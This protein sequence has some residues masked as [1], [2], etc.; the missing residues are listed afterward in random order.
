VYTPKTKHGVGVLYRYCS[1]KDLGILFISSLCSI[2]SGAAM[3][4]MTVLFGNLQGIFQ[5]YFNGDTTYDYF[6]ERLVSFVLYLVY[7][8]IGEFVVTYVATVGFI[9]TGERI[10]ARIRE[11]YLQCCMRQNIA[12]FDNVGAGEITTHITSNTNLIQDGI[13]QK[14]STTLAAIA[15]ITTAF[16]IGFVNYWKLTLILVSTVAA[17]ML[18]MSVISRLMLANSKQ[19]LGAYVQGGS[20]ADEVI[21]SIRNTVAFGTQSRLAKQY[22]GH[23]AKAEHYGFRFQCAVGLMVAS[24]QLIMFLSYALAFWQGSKYLLNGEVPL[25]NVLTIMMAVMTGAFTLGNVAPN[26]QA[27]MAAIAAAAKIFNTIDRKSPIDPSDPTGDKLDDIIGNLRLENIQHRY[28]S[29][30]EVLV[31]SNVNLDIPAGKT[32]AL[33][34]MSGSGKSTIIGLVERFYT[35]IEGTIY[36]DEHDISTLNLRWLRQQMALVS[37]EPTL[38][39]TTIFHNIR[40]G[41]IGT[42]FDSENDES[43][44]QRVIN[45]AKKAFAHEFITNLQE[46]YDTNVGERGFLLSGG[47]KQRIAIARAIVSD[48]KSMSTSVSQFYVAY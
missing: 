23:L 15:T 3:P 8:G 41:L 14:V 26:I 19:S 18:N 24:L 48:P 13:S 2:A 16:V 17:W 12:F 22:D 25:S 37:Q 32:T 7:L 46:G 6:Q 5:D 10:T 33:V 29:R 44:R 35:P 36:L 42:R 38:F 40:H 11:H 31:M 30:P 39:G 1:R 47:Q 28:P 21:T 43:Q 9:Y 34:G 4:L 27:F 45:A 20:L